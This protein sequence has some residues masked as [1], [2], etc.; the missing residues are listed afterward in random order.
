MRRD[1]RS[2]MVGATS[3]NEI[4]KRARAAARGANALALA[5]APEDAGAGWIMLAA[6]AAVGIS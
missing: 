3:V 6:G 1:L 4:A 2:A 5:I